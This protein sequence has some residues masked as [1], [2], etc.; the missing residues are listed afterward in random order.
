MSAVIPAEVASKANG[1]LAVRIFSSST[2][3]NLIISQHA[4]VVRGYG[5]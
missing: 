3:S 4:P 2:L 5:G 1:V